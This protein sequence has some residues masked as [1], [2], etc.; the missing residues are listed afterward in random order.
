MLASLLFDI[1]ICDLLFVDIKSDIAHYA[2]STTPY[3]CNQDCG[4]LISNL[5]LT[6]DKVFSWCDYNCHLF[7]YSRKRSPRDCVIELRDNRM[8][9]TLL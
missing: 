6:L 8:F 7:M 5:E 2:G 3:E 4:N 1:D 9:K